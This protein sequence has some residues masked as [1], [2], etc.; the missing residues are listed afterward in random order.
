LLWK[1]L[2]VYQDTLINRKFNRVL[3]KQF[4]ASLL[5]KSLN[6]LKHVMTYGF[7]HYSLG[8]VWD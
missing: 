6:Y 1:L 2:Y 3:K 5:N 8:L 4:N 7:E